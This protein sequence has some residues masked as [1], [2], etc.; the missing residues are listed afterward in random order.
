MA[1]NSFENAR[2][3]FITGSSQGLGKALLEEVLE[4]GERAVATA[5]KPEVLAP[6]AEKYPTSQRLLQ[7]LDVTNEAQIIEAFEATEKHFGRLDVVVNNAGYGLKGEI[8]AIPEDQARKQIE[9]LFWG[10]VHI[11]KEAIKFMRDINPPGLGGRVLN[12]SSIGGYIANTTLAYYSAGKFALEGFTEAFTKEMLP[13]WNIKGVIIEPG[14]FPTEWARS[15]MVQ[16]PVHPKYDSPDSPSVLFRKMGENSTAIGNNRKAAQAMMHI[17]SMPDPPLR[18]QLGT[19][20]WMLAKFKASKT[21]EDLE[22]H[23]DIS[24]STNGDAV[25]VDEV[26]KTLAQAFK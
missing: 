10:P 4:R 16:Y 7:P 19:E 26:K 21:I 25:D 17:A 24:H 18:I 9:V 20:A 5:R 11:T 1:S 6:L 3:W 8:E 23:A 13:S 22:K 15:S 12:I 2:V 14:G